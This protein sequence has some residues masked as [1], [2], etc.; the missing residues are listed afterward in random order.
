MTNEAISPTQV[1]SSREWCDLLIQALDAESVASPLSTRESTLI[2]KTRNMYLEPSL[3]DRNESWGFTADVLGCI[4]V[5][6]EAEAGLTELSRLIL[7]SFYS[8]TEA[9]QDYPTEGLQG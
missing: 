9:I 5:A 4:L 8:D 7:D 1:V 6:R 2:E 3:E